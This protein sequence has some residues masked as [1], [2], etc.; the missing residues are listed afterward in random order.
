[1]LTDSPALPGTADPTTFVVV[2]ADL[3]V[4]KSN[5]VNGVVAGEAS[6]YTVVVTNVGPSPVTGAR[7][8][9]AITAGLINPSWT[10][11]AVGTTCPL[12]GASGS[13]DVLLDLPVNAVATFVITTQ[14]D[15]VVGETISN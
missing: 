15:A 13:I 4:S 11:S 3:Q 6:R 10:C 5:G 2:G 12:A 14:V 1:A 9:D 7:V 8:V